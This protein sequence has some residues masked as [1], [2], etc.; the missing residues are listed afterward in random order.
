MSLLVASN[1]LLWVVVIL[2]AV[3][4]YAL[5]RQIECYGRARGASRGFHGQSNH[6]D[7]AAGTCSEAL[8][9]REPD[10]DSAALGS[11]SII[12]LFALRLSGGDELTPAL[13]GAARAESDW[14]DAVVLVSDGEEQDH[15]AC[16]L[17]ARA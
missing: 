7:W 5:P 8:T 2:L 3:M 4:N 10:I 14:V 12:A 1:I 11:I 6:R 16:R 15:K 17:S 9:L 13:M